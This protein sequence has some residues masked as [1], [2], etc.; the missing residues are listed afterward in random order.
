MKT[1]SLREDWSSLRMWA[2]N[3]CIK[4]KKNTAAALRLRC[5]A[6]VCAR[7][8]NGVMKKTRVECHSLPAEL[9]YKQ[10]HR[11]KKNWE[12]EESRAALLTRASWTICCG[13]ILRIH[14]WLSTFYV[15]WKASSINK[16]AGSV[17]G[18]AQTGN[19]NLKS[20]KPMLWLRLLL[21]QQKKC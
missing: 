15:D 3:R 21:R 8:F 11:F 12:L 5:C 20:G 18:C 13:I 7:L 16:R 19:P 14:S 4:S 6:R 10:V 2:R 17:T 1:T 9:S